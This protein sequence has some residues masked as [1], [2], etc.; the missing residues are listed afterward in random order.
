MEKNALRLPAGFESYQEARQA[1]F[2]RMKQLKESGARVIGLFCSYVPI[3]LVYAAG[4]IPVGLCASSEEPIAAAEAN[5]PRNL[6]PL[7]KASYGFALTDTCPYF[8]FSDL[9][10]AETTCD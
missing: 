1:G 5:L 4:A 8:Y 6:C 7:I 2:L 10:V 9:V 3:E